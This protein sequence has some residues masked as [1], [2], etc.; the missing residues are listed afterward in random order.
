MWEIKHTITG[1]HKGHLWE[2]KAEFKCHWKNMAGSNESCF[3]CLFTLLK[4][5]LVR[6]IFIAHCFAAYF[7][8]TEKY[9]VVNPLQ[10]SNDDLILYIVSVRNLQIMAAV[11]FLLLVF[12]I[13]LSSYLR[14]IDKEQFVRKMES[15]A[16]DLD[17]LD[18]YQLAWKT[19]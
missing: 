18:K 9:G 6:I 5:V 1:S 12:E 15:L 10:Q 2:N 7:C 17:Q 14:S 8:V 3:G 11:G 4:F 19:E 13:L 16:G